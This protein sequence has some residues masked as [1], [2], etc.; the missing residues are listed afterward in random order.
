MK[1]M[2]LLIT[3]A[4]ASCA[5]PRANQRSAM[6]TVGGTAGLATVGALGIG[7]IGLA[8]DHDFLAHHGVFTIGGAVAGGIAG[9]FLGQCARDDEEGGAC[10]VGVIIADSVLGAILT[11]FGTFY[12]LCATSSCGPG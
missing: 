8:T 9:H 10:R 2:T 7:S 6:W 5:A 1:A 12:V 11:T 3:L 4:L